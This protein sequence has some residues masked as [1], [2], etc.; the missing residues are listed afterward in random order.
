[1]PRCLRLHKVPPTAGFCAV[2]GARVLPRWVWLCLC[3]LPL[4]LIYTMVVS[5]RAARPSY[6]TPARVVVTVETTR[7]VEVTRIITEAPLVV[8][9]RIIIEAPP[10]VQT[11]FVTATEPAPT[12][13]GPLGTADPSPIQTFAS[14][15][16]SIWAPTITETPTPSLSPTAS[17]TQTASPTL[18]R[19]VKPTL[20]W[21][22][23]PSASPTVLPTSIATQFPR[24]ALL[25]FHGRYVTAK[26]AADG[27]V[28]RQE[29]RLDD[30]CGWFTV[31][32]QDK[33]KVALLTCY[34]RYVTA[35][36]T[37]T[38]RWDWRLRQETKLEDCGNFT[39]HDLG[40]G[41]V[42]FETCAGKFITAGD[43]NWSPGLQWL[44][45]AETNNL[46]A[47]EHFTLH[48]P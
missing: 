28:L 10:I 6:V 2:C 34:N 27:W 22:P 8:V 43:G 1:M 20:T 18:T 5:S 32:P 14:T 41:E 12:P 42:A 15:L 46:L 30:K 23:T 39:V 25:S 36:S 31:N 13:T 26:G 21:T 37:G 45:V 16:S 17:P 44:V 33:G 29:P 9:T 48:A 40:N 24:V 38:F 11:R 35:P 4:I 19:T 3:A 7:L 47:W